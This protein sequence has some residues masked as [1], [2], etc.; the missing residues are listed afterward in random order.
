M[1]FVGVE[2]IVRSMGVEFVVVNM[3]VGADSLVKSAYSLKIG[4]LQLC[5]LRSSF[6]RRDRGVTCSR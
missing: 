5:L 3:V 1:G 2:S 4:S 6:G